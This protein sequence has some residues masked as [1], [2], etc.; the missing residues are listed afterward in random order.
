MKKDCQAEDLR[1]KRSVGVSRSGKNFKLGVRVDFI[2][3]IVILMLCN[4]AQAAGFKIRGEMSLLEISNSN[5]VHGQ[6][7]DFELSNLNDQWL[8]R[9]LST[10]GQAHIF[11]CDGSNVYW[12]FQDPV[13]K[14]RLNLKSYVGCVFDGVYPVQSPSINTC[15]PW[16]AYCSG[17]Y[18]SSGQDNNNIALPAP[19]LCAWAM[20][21]AHI[22]SARYVP[23]NQ[24]NGLPQ[25]L[26]YIP[27]PKRMEDLENGVFHTSIPP[28]DSERDSSVLLL[29][30]YKKIKSPEA[31]Y[32]VIAT[33]NFHNIVLPVEFHFDNYIFNENKKTA[34]LNGHL[35]Q[36]IVGKMLSIEPITVLDPLPKS[37][38]EVSGI[39]VGDYRFADSKTGVVFI[40]YDAED[41][42]WITDKQDPRLQRLFLKQADIHAGLWSV[43]LNSKFWIFILFIVAAAFP[44]VLFF[45]QRNI[46]WPRRPKF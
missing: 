26:E 45:R 30:H 9:V 17:T 6:K 3:F 32:N 12:L 13:A 25:Q 22:Y 42:K 8:Y 5:I 44:L 19:W 10:N 14:K 27:N 15:L 20:P 46:S 11:G 37:G 39:S 40:N 16:L 4:S 1:R 43:Q 29:I 23:I 31:V 24:S 36:R 7:W 41:A 34:Q 33:T 28:N 38:D 2:F 21:I 35:S 18:L